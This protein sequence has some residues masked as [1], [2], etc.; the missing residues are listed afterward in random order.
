VQGLL[1][2]ESPTSIEQ[3][4]NILLC[5]ISASLYRASVTMLLSLYSLLSRAAS[6][7][8]HQLFRKSFGSPDPSI[9]DPCLQTDILDVIPSWTST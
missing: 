5:Q 9:E 6:C 7:L 8:L 1:H 2:Q 3:E 4:S